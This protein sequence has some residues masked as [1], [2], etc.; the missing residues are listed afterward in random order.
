MPGRVEI[1]NIALARL[2]ESPIQTLD[3]GSTPAN[4]ALQLYDIERQATL[5]DYPWNFALKQASLARVDKV[6][7][8]F[9][10]AFALPG[11][12]LRAVR[13]W[14][15]DREEIVSFTVRNGTLFT[16]PERVTLEYVADVEDTGLFDAKFIEAFSYKLAAALAMTV[17]GSPELMAN[18]TNLYQTLVTDAAAKSAH[19]ERVYLSDNPYLEARY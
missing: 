1:V 19:E 13:L 10:T 14:G 7:F 15:A 11:D 17:K 3:E 9:R 5:R 18:Y 8:E 16:Q 2:G 12:C 4:A 6:A